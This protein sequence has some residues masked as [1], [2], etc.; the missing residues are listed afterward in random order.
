MIRAQR[1]LAGWELFSLVLWTGGLFCLVAYVEPAAIAALKDNAD[2]AWEV[3]NG[4]YTRFGTIQIVFAAVVLLSNV[5]KMI[6]FRNMFE[7]QRISVLMAAIAFTLTC[8][9]VLNLQPRLEAM[10]RVSVPGASI[11]DA[12]KFSR[13][14]LQYLTLLK[15]NMVLGLFL[16]YTY[17]SFEERKLQSIVKVLKT[18]PDEVS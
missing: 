16:A 8:F 15:V 12:A 14:H 6:V 17:R 4:V 1:I 13:L 7:M 18:P 5:V 2:L 11:D 9:C 10:P 3:R